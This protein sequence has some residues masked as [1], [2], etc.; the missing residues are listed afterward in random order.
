MSLILIPAGA[1]RIVAEREVALKKPVALKSDETLV[2]PTGQVI[3]KGETSK[4]QIIT[5][6]EATTLGLPQGA[7]YQ[8][9]PN[10]E[11]TLVAGT[12][13]KAK[14]L[15][16]D[17]ANQLG[18]PTAGGQKYQVDANGKLDLVQGTAKIN[19]L[20]ALRNTIFTFLK[21]VKKLMSNS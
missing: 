5:P 7:V 3:F 8:R 15:T 17:E 2:S 13:A 1:F 21:A 19:L 11:I 18:L 14:I 16:T 12:T 20:Q 9:K 10:G 6:D 4:A